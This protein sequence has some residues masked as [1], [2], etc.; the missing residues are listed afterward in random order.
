MNSHVSA[1][2][3]GVMDMERSKRFYTDGLAISLDPSPTNPVSTRAV[4]RCAHNRL[5]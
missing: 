2:L 5:G 3:L 4:F 1:I